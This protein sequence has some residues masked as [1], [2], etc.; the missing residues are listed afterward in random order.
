[1]DFRVKPGLS[2]CLLDSG[3]SPEIPSELQHLFQIVIELNEIIHKRMP[4]IVSV[5]KTL[6]T[7]VYT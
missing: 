2:E 5:K 4:G 6:A 7:I 1:M 3:S